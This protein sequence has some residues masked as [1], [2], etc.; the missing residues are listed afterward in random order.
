[1]AWR[2]ITE[3]RAETV[4]TVKQR[5]ATQET[6]LQEFQWS[7]APALYF[8]DEI[9]ALSNRNQEDIREVHKAKLA[10]PG[11]RLIQEGAET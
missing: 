9:L 4:E 1:M 5:N 6:R 3:K 8:L 2:L 7:E 11:V 10:Y